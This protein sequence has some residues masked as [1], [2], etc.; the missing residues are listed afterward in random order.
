MKMHLAANTTYKVIAESGGNT[1]LS[2]RAPSDTMAFR[3][4]VGEAVDYYFIY[5]PEPSRVIA[6]YRDF[7]GAAPLLPLWAYGFWQCRERYS[8]QQQILDTVAE[9]RQRKIPVDVIVQDWQYWGKYG[10]NAMRFDERYYP[11]P[12]QMMTQLHQENLHLVAS[13]WAKFG[14]ETAVD[15]DMKRDHLLLA[16][17][18]DRSGTGRDTGKRG[19]GGSIQSKGARAVLVGDE[20]RVVPRRPRRVVVG[21][22]RTRGRCAQRRDDISWPWRIRAQRISAFRNHCR[23]PGTTPNDRTEACRDSKPVRVCGSAAK[24]DNLMVRRHL[25][26]L[27]DT[28]PADSSRPQLCRCPDFLTG[29]QTWEV[30]SVQPTNIHRRITTNC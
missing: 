8:S 13:V 29:R 9:F 24:R 3:S 17:E 15:Q 18:A 16:S 25:G 23:L 2:V 21:C 14:T 27:G 12:A 6:E 7:T 19:L 22:F 30:S 20:S 11:D 5:G 10:W 28:S 4:Q 26:E 1:E